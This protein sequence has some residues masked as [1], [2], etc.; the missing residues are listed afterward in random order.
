[1]TTRFLQVFCFSISQS[2]MSN[3]YALLF[4]YSSLYDATTY[5][6]NETTMESIFFGD[7]LFGIP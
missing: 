2:I 1:M 5:L 3:V 4:Q 6:I 7:S